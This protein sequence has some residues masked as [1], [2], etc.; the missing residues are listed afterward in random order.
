MSEERFEITVPANPRPLRVVRNFL[1]V[2]AGH[3]PEVKLSPQALIELQLA[4]QEACINAIRYGE[5]GR[6]DAR[7]R[8][9][10]LVTEDRLTVEIRDR[11]P[12]FDPSA[13]SIP[14]P[15]ELREGGYGVHIMRRASHALAVRREGGEFV[16]S[17]TRYYDEV[18]VA[19]SGRSR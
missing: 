9:A 12:G 2:L 15:E 13:V 17:L 6:L 10:F 5:S 18:A 14:D 1:E 8:V 3:C 16:V 7:V 19:A 11:G 4:I